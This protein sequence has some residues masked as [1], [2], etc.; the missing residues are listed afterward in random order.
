MKKI[1]S[2]KFDDL[3]YLMDEIKELAQHNKDLSENN[4]VLVNKLKLI[5]KAKL[6]DWPSYLANQNPN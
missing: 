2:K 4:I 1:T 3:Q 6:T 5:K